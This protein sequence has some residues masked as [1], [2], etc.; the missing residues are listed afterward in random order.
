VNRVRR[1]QTSPAFW[2]A[3]SVIFTVNALLSA[4]RGDWLMAVLQAVTGMLASGA[5]VVES[6]QPR[7]PSD[8]SP[9][10]SRPVE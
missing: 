2:L 9:R 8:P 5:A 6:G 7:V 4:A 1:V 3:C 10:P